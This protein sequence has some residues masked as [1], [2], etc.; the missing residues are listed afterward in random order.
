MHVEQCLSCMI[1]LPYIAYI[2]I[3][4]PFL[5]Y[6]YLHGATIRYTHIPV[7]SLYTSGTNISPKPDG[8]TPKVQT[9]LQVQENEFGNCTMVKL[10]WNSHS[11][12]SKGNAKRR[13]RWYIHRTGLG[14]LNQPLCA[15][16]PAPN[17]WYGPPPGPGG[18][19]QIHISRHIVGWE[20]IV[21]PQ[22]AKW[23]EPNASRRVLPWKPQGSSN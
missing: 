1:L 13:S 12:P 7:W 18:P 5:L 2:Y 15:A 10:A 20:T 3:C 14:Y 6:V 17:L 8:L 11:M 22:S 4:T 9:V 21:K 23:T 19:L 16:I